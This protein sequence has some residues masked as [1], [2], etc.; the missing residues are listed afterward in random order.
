MPTLTLSLLP[1]TFAVC[2]LAP[3][4]PLGVP[5]GALSSVT[6]TADELSVVCE[7]HL[8]PAGARAEGGWAALK[9]HG[10]FAF[11]L[12]GILAA[13]LNPLRGADVGIFAISTFD[14]DYVLVKREKLDA[15]LRAL[16]AA[17]HTILGDAVVDAAE[18][19]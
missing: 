8:A 11:T 7:E 16:R 6:R 5:G 14:T 9:L 10:P 1:Q 13:V 2:R 18:R 4:A 17:G 3:D 15:A 12:T 19:E